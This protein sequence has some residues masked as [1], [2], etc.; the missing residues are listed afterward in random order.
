MIA[1]IIVNLLVI[2]MQTEFNLIFYHKSIHTSQS[3]SLQQGEMPGQQQITCKGRPNGLSYYKV[4][5]NNSNDRK[6]GKESSL[7]VINIT[8]G[9]ST[10]LVFDFARDFL[11][12]FLNMSTVGQ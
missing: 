12:Q 1:F 4:K 3:G 8:K 6:D 10:V 9:L 7:G 2:F 11:R 5:L